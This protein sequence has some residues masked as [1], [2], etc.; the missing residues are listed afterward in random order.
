MV[1]STVSLVIAV[2]MPALVTARSQAKA[3]VCRSNLRQLLLANIEYSNDN[4]GFCVPGAE[5]IWKSNGGSKRWHGQRDSANEAFD[6]LRGPFAEYMDDGK[7]KECPENTDFAKGGLWAD[8]FEQ[9][10][11][12]YGYNLTYIGGRLWS[13]NLDMERKYAETARLVEIRRPRE[14][15]MFADCAMSVKHGVYIEYSFAEPVHPIINGKV[16]EHIFLSPSIHFRHRDLA[17]IGWAD[18]HIGP[19]PMAN[20]DGSN[21]WNVNSAKM[22]LGWFEPVDNT[23]FDLQ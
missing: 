6:P 8:N 15:L 20:M 23:P 18:G 11:G 9:G 5:D 14:T 19:K 21:V 4:D 13:V 17:N 1:V 10:C 7:V 16:K 2:S 12:G 3:V 22:N